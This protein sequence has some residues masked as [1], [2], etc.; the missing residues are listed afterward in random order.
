MVVKQCHLIML[1]DAVGQEFKDSGLWLV[2]APWSGS[3]RKVGRLEVTWGPEC[4][5]VDA[6]PWLGPQLGSHPEHLHVACASLE[7]GGLR[8]AVPPMWQ[9]RA[10]KAGL[11]A[12]KEKAPL[13]F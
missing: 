9:F 10:P 6:D 4:L 2:S 12:H 5:A 8:E 11:Q 13:T 7:D 1:T 3:A